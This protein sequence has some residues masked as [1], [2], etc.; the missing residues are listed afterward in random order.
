MGEQL[1][2]PHSRPMPAVG[3]GCHELRINDQDHSWRIMYR[4]DMDAI[5]ILEV[6]EKKTRETPRH[7]VDL[8]TDRLK[9][10]DHEA[11]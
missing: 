11:R 9:R 10:Y 3:R 7:V 2:M 8:C 1:E 6:F 5:L 4:I